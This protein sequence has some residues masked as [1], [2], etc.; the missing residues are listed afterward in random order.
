MRYFSV[1]E[2]A[3]LQTFP[4]DYL[5]HGSWTESMRQ[6]GNAVPVR[7]AEIVAASVREQILRKVG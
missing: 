1:R 6:L 5:I 3:R 7:L 4:D 2:S